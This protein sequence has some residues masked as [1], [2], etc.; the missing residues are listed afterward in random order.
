MDSFEFNKVFG[1]VI[2]AVLAIK[3]VGIA[4]ES[5]YHN[6]GPKEVAFPVVVAEAAPTAAA[7]AEPVISIAELMLTADAGKGEGQMRACAAC[8][9]FDKGGANKAG[10]NLWGVMGRDIASVAG[11][12]YSSALTAV[13]G[14]WDYEKMNAWL[15]N[16]KNFAKGTSMSYAGQ[17]RDGRRADMIAYLRSLSDNPIPLPAVEAAVEEVVEEVVETAEGAVE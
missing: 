2:S 13:D 4:S 17:R 10:P 11:F 8:H 3:V 6:E 7:A 1:A 16:P 9:S 15:K 5:F 12:T 14:A